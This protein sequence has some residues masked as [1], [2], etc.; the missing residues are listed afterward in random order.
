M[1][2]LDQCPQPSQ[3]HTRFFREY[4]QPCLSPADVHSLETT[5]IFLPQTHCIKEPSTTGWRYVCFLHEPGC[6]WLDHMVRDLVPLLTSN[7]PSLSEKCLFNNRNTFCVVYLTAKTLQVGEAINTTMVAL[8]PQ[9]IFSMK[10]CSPP[11][12]PPGC[13]RQTHSEPQPARRCPCGLWL[14][15]WAR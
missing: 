2:V 12:V 4:N 5:H 7:P 8:H 1:N 14:R 3:R 9:Y 13:L 6:R 11:C 10:V 15:R